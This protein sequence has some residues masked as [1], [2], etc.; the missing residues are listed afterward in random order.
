MTPNW[1][2]SLCHQLIKREGQKR[3]Q[4]LANTYQSAFPRS[5]SDDYSVAVALQDIDHIETLS[6]ERPVALQLHYIGTP[7][8]LHLRLYQW[9]TPIPLSDILPMLENFNLRAYSQDQHLIKPKERPLIWMSDFVLSYNET[10]LAL[11]PV[12]DLFEAAFIKIYEG[13]AENDGFNKLILGAQLSWQDV[14]ILRAYAKY[15][16]Q[17]GFRFSQSYIEATLIH[18]EK[19]AQS[20]IAL[21]K[22]KHQPPHQARAKKQ[23]E[24][25]EQVILNALESVASLDEDRIIRRLLDL[26]KATVRTNF[27]Q[28]INGQPK[29]YLSIK[30]DSKAIPELPL[31]APLYEIFVYSPRFEGI[32]LR[33]AKVARGGIRWSDRKEDFRTEILGLMKAQ[34]VKNAVIVPSGAKG[35]FVL[36]TLPPQSTREETQQEVHACYQLFMRGLLDL[37]DNIIQNKVVHP[38]ETVIFDDEDPYLVVA[39]DKGTATFSDTANQIAAE[40]NFWLG[41]AFASGGSHGYDHKAIGITAKGAWES[42]K[43]H[44]GELNIDLTRTDITVI[45][46]G[47]MSGDVFG[48]GAL[49]SKRIKLVAAFDHRH[50][51][52][53]P[54]PNPARSYQER[55]RLFKLPHS[56]WEDYNAKLISTGGGVFKRSLKSIPI[57]QPM[58]Q[59]LEINHATLTPSELIQA[60]LK[61]PV[62]L[63]FN[64]G[65]GTYVKASTESHE[66]VA[67]HT[68]D[69]CRINGNELRV[70]VVGEGGN[71][72]FTQR[73]RIE[74]ALQGGLINTDFIDNSAGVDCSDHEVNLKILLANAIQEGE[75]AAKKRNPLLVSLTEEI[76]SSVLQDNYQQALVMSFSAYHAKENI[77][78]HLNY[79]KELEALGALD[80]HVEYIP[81]DK[82]I[83]DRKAAGLGLTRPELAVLLTYSKIYI[84]H[85]ILRSQLT[86]D[87]FFGQWAETALPMGVQKK[88]PKALRKHRLYHEII[89]TQLSNLIVNQTGITFVY[90]LQ[91]ET[92]AS[93]EKIVRA[94]IA[95]SHIFDTP[96]LQ[97]TI[98]QLGIQVPLKEQYNMLFHVR[99]LLHISSR[100][101]LR[102]GYLKKDLSL[103]IEAFKEPIHTLQNVIP[104]L[105]SGYA[106]QY[107]ETL[108]D[109]FA[110]AGLPETLAKKIA[111]YRAMYLALNIVDIAATHRLDL[112]KTAKVYFEAGERIN[113]LWFRDQLAADSQDGHWNIMA[114]LSLRDELDAC[115]RNF[116]V[117]VMKKDAKKHTATHLIEQWSKRNKAL[118]ERW[119]KLLEMLHSSAHVDYTMFFVVVRELLN[120]IHESH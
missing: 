8:Q 108:I 102:N 46:I 106:K 38:E 89:A 6:S 68:N 49:Y 73:G 72:G 35:G 82:E 56:S 57:S 53:D 16:R 48:N 62:D 86:K 15:L 30:F 99:R 103:L 52:I 51:F 110:K 87:P 66:E 40:Y 90:R 3:G 58:K 79:I 84:K 50:I 20:L 4:S 32:H 45:G 47:D 118:L 109:E 111:T 69:Y 65:I 71:L 104:T 54:T 42:V 5:Y 92:G 116:T 41:D 67:D 112:L 29:E 36:K 23:V 17:I 26:I 60:I 114:R 37:T 18:H 33:H 80:R 98:E 11:A 93:I 119:E 96:Q 100:W 63:L 59:L 120:L 97:K 76:A 105:I 1:N 94:Y 113:L 55:L 9:E 2:E 78:L 44:F 74:Y 43:R 31:P 77:N 95:S 88:Y 85:E 7:K 10:E 21:F 27:F 19:I 12:K 28:K 107:L 22:A 117:A 34:T 81:S 14:I 70:K 61:A 91:M 39:A 101:F 24:E 75:L 13:H 115:Q 25:I 64:G 83:L